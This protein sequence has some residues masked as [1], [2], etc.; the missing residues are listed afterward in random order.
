MK[1][2]PFFSPQS[3][4]S[5]PPCVFM[6]CLKL[7]MER[8]REQ[9]KPKLRIEAAGITKGVLE[10][11]FTL[12]I[13]FLYQE[14]NCLMENN[15]QFYSGFAS[16]KSSCEVYIFNAC[17]C[18][19]TLH[20][21]S[22][23]IMLWFYSPTAGLYGKTTLWAGCQGKGWCGMHDLALFWHCSWRLE[24]PWSPW[25]SLHL[26]SCSDRNL[27][28]S[29]FHSALQWMAVLLGP[30]PW[31]EHRAGIFTEKAFTSQIR[32]VWWREWS[33]CCWTQRRSQ[34]LRQR[35]LCQVLPACTPRI[36]P[37][38]DHLQSLGGR[39]GDRWEVRR[40]NGFAAMWTNQPFFIF[41]RAESRRRLLSPEQCGPQLCQ[42]LCFSQG[43]RADLYI[44]WLYRLNPLLFGLLLG[45]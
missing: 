2:V 12:Q 30:V 27:N 10:C 34:I 16:L 18:T 11:S 35:S 32:R 17:P 9:M 24:L 14:W 28:E 25:W 7:P 36:C 21:H 23:F 41:H 8:R 31:A 15:S 45:Y 44:F 13:I 29:R 43:V 40:N 3:C 33:C 22:E 1:L 4:P 20:I 38:W 6:G 39:L 19:H 42:F 26:S 5:F 37:P